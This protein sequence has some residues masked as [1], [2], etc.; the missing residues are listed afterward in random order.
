MRPIRVG[1]LA[2]P[3]A[4]PLVARRTTYT[5]HTPWPSGQF[6]VRPLQ[7]ALRAGERGV[8]VAAHRDARRNNFRCIRGSRPGAPVYN[9]RFL[10]LTARGFWL[11]IAAWP[12]GV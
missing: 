7:T 3:L 4:G 8:S 2:W 12:L 1:P 11:G 10:P 5:S 6:S 9:A